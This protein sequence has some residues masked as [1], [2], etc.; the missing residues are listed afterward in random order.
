MKQSSSN[1][2]KNVLLMSVLRQP[3]RNLV[4]FLLIGAAAFAFVLRTTEFLV[5]R[6][7]IYEI[8]GFYQSIGFLHMP[9]EAYS[10]IIDGAD[11]IAA[12]PHMG[13]EDRRRGAEAVM[14]GIQNYH[15]AGKIGD[16]GG[17]IVH[18]TEL[19][20]SPI[21]ER[22]H[23]AYF[24]G[25]INA[26]R[27]SNHPRTGHFFELRISVDEVIIGFPEHVMAGH[28]MVMRYFAADAGPYALDDMEIGERYLLRGAFYWVS[29][30]GRGT[31]TW[32]PFPGTEWNIL[33]MHPLIDY[34]ELWYMHVPQGQVDFSTPGLES[35]AADIERQHYNHSAL[36][37]RTTADMTAMPVMQEEFSRVV[38]AEG[39]F[40]T[41]EDH[42]EQRPVAVIH[43]SLA[44]FRGIEIGDTITVSIPRDQR[45][46]D[47]HAVMHLGGGAHGNFVFGDGM[48]DFAIIGNPDRFIVEGLELEVVGTYIKL[49]NSPDGTNLHTFTSILFAN[50][51]YIPDSLLPPGF[52]PIDAL[53]GYSEYLWDSWYSFTLNN[54]RNERAFLNENRDALAALGIGVHI[55]PSGAEGFWDMAEPALLSITFNAVMFWVVLILVFGL[56]AFLY[57]HQRRRDFAILR[58]L[59]NPA[60]KTVRQ[61]VTPAALFGLPAIAMGGALGW[62]LAL[63]SARDTLEPM[64]AFADVEIALDFPIIWL[65]AQLSV[66]II[67]LLAMVYEGAHLTSKRPVL[68]LLQ[69]KTTKAAKKNGAQSVARPPAAAVQHSGFEKISNASTASLLHKTTIELMHPTKN[70]HKNAANA[71]FILR[72]IV[73]APVKSIL[74][75][76]VALFFVAAFGVLNQT[77]IGTERDIEHL[78]DNTVV[79]GELGQ[80]N[81]FMAAGSTGIMTRQ[82]VDR[83]LNLGY[84]ESYYA[85]AGFNAFI[86]HAGADGNFP[87]GIEGNFWDEFWQYIRDEY[88]GFPARRM[89]GMLA[90]NNSEIFMEES[91]QQ[92]NMPG[93]LSP[94]I[95]D[96]AGVGVATDPLEIQFAPGFGW[97]DFVYDDSSLQTPV[98]VIL[99]VRTL[100]QRGLAVGD[101]AFVGH[102]RTNSRRAVEFP[103]KIIGEHNGGVSR[104]IGSNATL[105]PLSAL[106]YVRGQQ[107]EYTV[108]RFE[109][110][111]AYNREITTVRSDIESIAG[112]RTQSIRMPLSVLINDNELRTVVGSLE[113]NLYLLQLLY[114]MAIMLSVVIG[115]GMAMLLM[116]QSAKTAAIMR[117]LGYGKG[118]ARVMLCTEHIIVAICGII[119]GLAAM[120]LFGIDL[121]VQLPLLAG[122]YL[123]GVA[124]GS[125]AGAAIITRREPLELLQ[126]RE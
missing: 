19:A 7:R 44:M 33:Y 100:E 114:P 18:G 29:R 14:H 5:V 64:G 82:T 125:T 119:T 8:G 23:Y 37:L 87:T 117:I 9:G 120:P 86:F 75:M 107:M 26:I 81:P 28:D 53:H 109:I 51:V 105:L 85:E 122:L 54:S 39:R 80:L 78:Y 96:F 74:T 112:A 16:A 77:I 89:D 15:T 70:S 111:P 116:L 79:T 59:G 94:D 46:V 73:R 123:A 92:H 113:Q 83:I 32:P 12:S 41:H 58:A 34:Q 118:H 95:I 55:L 104:D 76:A 11:I 45:I 1:M 3:M 97:D 65:L 49:P 52:M 25:T 13:I 35:L 103:I 2:K 62:L 47:T 110:D 40:L 115:I 126:V 66:I 88:F 72:H 50:Y 20:H 121:T 69:G 124:I 108:F 4:L 30:Y 90:F 68:E 98:P 63:A 84:F 67:I 10:N 60:G 38:L 17:V 101:T 21:P 106:A 71:Q 31:R 43:A 93:G 27:E 57:L 56:I 22:V 91:S 36:W 99:S 6:D 61:V 24:Y 102:T 48:M 42:L